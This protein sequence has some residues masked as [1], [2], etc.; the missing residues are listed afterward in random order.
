MGFF[1]LEIEHGHGLDFA[2]IGNAGFDPRA[3]FE[4]AQQRRGLY[5]RM[6][7]VGVVTRLKDKPGRKTP[8]VMFVWRYSELQCV[9]ALRE[10]RASL[11]IRL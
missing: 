1:L 4:E 10:S 3:P 11:Q 9:D 5:S 7:I 2:G 6:Q 8:I